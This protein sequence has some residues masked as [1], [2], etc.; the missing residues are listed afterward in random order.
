MTAKPFLGISLQDDS[1]GVT[2]VEVVDGSAAATA[3]IQ[4]GDV[5]T[6]IDNQPVT[7]P[8]KPPAPSALT[9]SA[10]RSRLTTPAMATCTVTATLG[11]Q[12]QTMQAQPVNPRGSAPILQ[13]RDAATAM[14]TTMAMAMVS[15]ATSRR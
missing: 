3:G 1:N 12:P 15:R 2:V 6:A 7:T 11:T 10:T 9:R 8:Q 14:V 4:A 13:G 5:I